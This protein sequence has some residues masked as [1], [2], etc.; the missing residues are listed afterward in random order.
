MQLSF[1]FWDN[2]DGERLRE[3][4]HHSFRNVFITNT[5][6]NSQKTKIN[7]IKLKKTFISLEL[8]NINIRSKFERMK[9]G[10]LRFKIIKKFKKNFECQKKIQKLKM[11]K[12]WKISKKKSNWIKFIFLNN[13]KLFYFNFIF[14]FIYL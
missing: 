7:F 8:T 4:S 11:S 14:I 9:F 5:A 10:G 3:I 12:K 2:F 1:N 13:N 6:Y